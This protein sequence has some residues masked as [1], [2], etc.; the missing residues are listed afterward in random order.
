MNELA[1]SEQTAFVSAPRAGQVSF[2][3][4]QTPKALPGIIRRWQ[5]RHEKKLMYA[6]LVVLQIAPFSRLL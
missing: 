5:R 3:F 1:S 2:A 6:S 4:A